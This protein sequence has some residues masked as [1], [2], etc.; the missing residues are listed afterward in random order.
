MFIHSQSSYSSSVRGTISDGHHQFCQKSRYHHF[1]I[2]LYKTE[3][4]TGKTIR[5]GDC[6][7]QSIFKL[8]SIHWTNLLVWDSYVMIQLC[9]WKYVSFCFLLLF[10][11]YLDVIISDLISFDCRLKIVSA[12]ISPSR[13][14]SAWLYCAHH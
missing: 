11:I 10:S 1:T 2:F 14:Y 12:Q 4:E 6:S 3:C 7:K 13:Y 8:I 5:N 9:H